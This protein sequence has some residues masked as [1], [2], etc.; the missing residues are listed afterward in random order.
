MFYL[1]DTLGLLL[2]SLSLVHFV[3]VTV[4]CCR[5]LT[6]SRVWL[7]NSGDVTG[8]RDAWHHTRQLWVCACHDAAVRAFSFYL[9]TTHILVVESLIWNYWDWW[10]GRQSVHVTSPTRHVTWHYKR[11]HACGSF[12]HLVF[13]ISVYYFTPWGYGDILTVHN[14]Q[15]LITHKD[16]YK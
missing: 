3:C 7:I 6:I 13:D 8:A 14:M 1:A 16:K 15:S 5:F 12:R 9:H 2:P 4:T 10:G 11:L